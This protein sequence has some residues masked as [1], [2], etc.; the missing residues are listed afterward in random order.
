[1][2]PARLPMARIFTCDWPAALFKEQNTI[3]MTTKELARNLLLG[4][5]SRPGADAGRPI[6]FIASC[7]S[8]V[9][10]IQAIVL[11]AQPGSTYATLWRAT[12]GIVFL[13]TPFRGTAFQDLAKLAVPFLKVYA[14]LAD[15]AV[16]D[17]L[18]SLKASTPFLQD[19]VGDFTQAYLQRNYPCKIEIFYETK[20]GNLLGNVMPNPQVANFFKQ[21]KLVRMVLIQIP[22]LTAIIQNLPTNAFLVS[23][24]RLFPS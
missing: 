11:A 24:C 14:G 13:A 6:I 2:L 5:Q 15:K 7:L 10:L 16:T 9:I 20:R 1:M 21:P 3:E 12:E 18:D 4:V 19:L 17:L 8:G 23:R 22:C